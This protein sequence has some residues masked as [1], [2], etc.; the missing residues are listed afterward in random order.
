MATVRQALRR[1]LLNHIGAKVE[2]PAELVF[3]QVPCVASPR[4]DASREGEPAVGPV[5]CRVGQ[6]MLVGLLHQLSHDA[7]RQVP[8]P[9]LSHAVH[10]TD[11]EHLVQQVRKRSHART[12]RFCSV[13]FLD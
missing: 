4:L 2:Y 7:V 8:A 9:D 3:R 5:S 11:L 6:G 12:S 13:L 1:E 10:V